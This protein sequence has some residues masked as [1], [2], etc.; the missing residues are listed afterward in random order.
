MSFKQGNSCSDQ[1]VSPGFEI[2]E[3]K[4]KGVLKVAIRKKKIKENK[5]LLMLLENN[6]NIIQQG[7]VNRALNIFLHVKL[8]LVAAQTI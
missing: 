1:L 5:I 6:I 4:V 2:T 3:E 8:F 7:R